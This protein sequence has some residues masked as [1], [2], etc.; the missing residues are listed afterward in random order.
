MNFTHRELFRLWLHRKG[1]FQ[2]FP[3]KL[4]QQNFDKVIVAQFNS[5]IVLRS[6]HYLRISSFQPL[7]EQHG[8]FGDRRKVPTSRP[9]SDKEIEVSTVGKSSHSGK[10]IEAG[11]KPGPKSTSGAVTGRTAIYRNRAF[12]AIQVRMMTQALEK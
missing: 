10:I 6:Y 5:K 12:K 7:L 2:T 9:R 4:L 11:T 8:T 1:N 3:S